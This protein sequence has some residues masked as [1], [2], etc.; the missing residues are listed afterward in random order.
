MAGKVLWGSYMESSCLLLRG[1]CSGFYLCFT[2]F[3][4]AGKGEPGWT[5][6]A[7]VVKSARFEVFILF[8]LAGLG[9]LCDVFTFQIY[10]AEG[11]GQMMILSHFYQTKKSSSICCQ[12]SDWLL[13]PLKPVST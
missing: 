6:E 12:V 1:L 10:S 9:Q 2:V 8:S 11:Q 4:E 13:N 3:K 7:C 5:R